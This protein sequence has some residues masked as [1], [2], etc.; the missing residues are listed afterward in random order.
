MNRDTIIAAII[1][2]IC[3]VTII[4]GLKVLKDT[5][6]IRSEKMADDEED[7]FISKFRRR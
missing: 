6:K 2:L 7:D 4:F 3:I 1:I 5:R